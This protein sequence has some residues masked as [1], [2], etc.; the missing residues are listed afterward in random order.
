[1]ICLGKHSYGTYVICPY[2]KD[3]SQQVLY[4]E[5]PVDDSKLHLAFATKS[6]MRTHRK[7]MCEG[8]YKNCPI[9]QMLNRKWDYD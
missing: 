1:M 2:Y 8:N 7:N 3:E 9:A 5:S 6:T 4:C